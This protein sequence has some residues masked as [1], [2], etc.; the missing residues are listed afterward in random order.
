MDS[1]SSACAGVDL[2]GTKIAIA[3][4]TAE[5]EILAQTKIATQPEN[6]PAAAFKR[7][8]E[9]LEDLSSSSGHG[10]EAIGLGVPGLADPARGTIEFLP[11]LPESWRGFSACSFLREATGRPVRILNDARLAALGE[12]HF[13]SKVTRPD[14]LVV[15]LGTGIGG[16]LIL[17]GRLRLGAFCAAGEVGHHTI[18]PD[19]VPCTC[20]SNGCLETL[21]SGPV[22]TREGIRLAQSGVAP[23]LAQLVHGDLNSIT[24]KEMLLA[25]EMGD[26][27]VAECIERAARYL[28]IGIANAVSITA[29]AEVVLCGGVAALGDRILNPVRNEVSKRVRMFPSSHVKV[30]CSRLGDAVGVLGALALAFFPAAVDGLTPE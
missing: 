15:T 18:L 28:G 19:G 7:V 6:G 5:G 13:G 10:F 17:D 25:A 23:H 2:G 3:I 20:G 22:L 8:A 11:N 4:G 27:K 16:G 21:F 14:L 12:F 26:E 29:V 30:D 9:A 24:P 1:R